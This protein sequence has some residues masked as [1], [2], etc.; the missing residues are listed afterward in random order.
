MEISLDKHAANQA[1]VKIKLN[2]ADY[3]PKVDAKIKD[4]AK[5]SSIKGFRPGKAPITMVKKMYG[6]SVLVDEINSILTSSLNDYLK[7]QTFKIL[8]DPLPMIEEAA[9]IDWDS[10]KEFEFKYKMM[11][12]R[13]T[14]FNFILDFLILRKKSKTS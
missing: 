2:E 3:Q 1:S 6:T 8:G 5:K 14:Q 13:A 4:Y 10:Q 11:T 7:A 12:K 9:N